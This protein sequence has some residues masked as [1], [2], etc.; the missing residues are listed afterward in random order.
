MSPNNSTTSGTLTPLQALILSRLDTATLRD[1]KWLA[2]AT[3]KRWTGGF[4][5]QLAEL[6][7]RG[8][9]T[10]GDNRRGYRLPENFSS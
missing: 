9:L 8:F 1:G 5:G 7:R 10:K 6:V 3:G 4:R 2:R